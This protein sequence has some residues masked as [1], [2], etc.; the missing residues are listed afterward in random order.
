LPYF[1]PIRY[2]A[3]DPMHNLFFGT[4]KH[5]ME[6]WTK[7]NIL[8]KQDLVITNQRRK[9]T[10]SYSP[11]AFCDV[12]P[13]EHLPYWL[14]FMKACSSLCTRYLKKENIQLADRYLQLFCSNH[15]EVNGK[16]A[17]TPNMHLHLHLKQCLNDYW[18]LYSLSYAF[19]RYYGMLGR[20]LTNQTVKEPQL[21]RKCLLMQDLRSQS[22]PCEGDFLENL[23][24]Q[25][26]LIISE[27]LL[28]ATTGDEMR[29]FVY[30]SA[31]ILSDGAD[32]KITSKKMLSSVE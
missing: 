5:C 2:T 13:R 25:H 29:Q 28:L 10:I 15:E 7:N 30:L 17:C 31:P 16:E 9:C 27:G 19:E 23:V 20:F 32:L 22:I 14:L 18:P 26:L 1:N 12:L 11:I 21:M 6:V 8:S 24:Y 3:I 4:A